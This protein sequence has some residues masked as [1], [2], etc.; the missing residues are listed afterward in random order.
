MLKEMMKG[1]NF[2]FNWKLK[3]EKVAI[4][5][6]DFVSPPKHPVHLHFWIPNIR[7]RIH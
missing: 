7:L 6:Y 1:M 3:I 4:V 2:N 5:A